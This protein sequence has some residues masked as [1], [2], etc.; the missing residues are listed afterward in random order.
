MGKER[1][2]KAKN[3]TRATERLIVNTEIKLPASKTNSFVMRPCK[4][5]EIVAERGFVREAA[6]FLRQDVCPWIIT[7]TAK[8]LWRS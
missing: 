6:P 4:N 7:A 3:L 5:K 2:N 8:G 1:C